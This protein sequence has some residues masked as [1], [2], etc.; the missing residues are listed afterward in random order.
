MAVHALAFSRLLRHV[1]VTLAVLALAWVAVPA[2][3]ADDKAAVESAKAL[4][5]EIETARKAKDGSA[6]SGL[7]EKL[8]DAH[9][10]IEHG[11]TRKKLQKAAGAVLKTKGLEATADKA[12]E[13]LAAL[14]DPKGAYGQLKRHMPGPKDK[15]PIDDKGRA[16]MAATAKLAPDSAIGSLEELATKSRDYVAAGLAIAA[17]GHYGKSKKRA[18]ILESLVKLISRFKPPVGQQIGEETQKRWTALGEPLIVA[19]NR[20]TNRK[21][22]SP[23]AWLTLWKENKKKPSELFND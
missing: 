11:A 2:E 10:G 13:A 18:A 17:L 9:N 3:A 15:T 7:L 5:D 16:V 4:A 23:D 6:L 14:N 8:P 20:L 22:N 1:P 19:C 21:E 12:I